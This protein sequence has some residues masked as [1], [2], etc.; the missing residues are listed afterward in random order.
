[1]AANRGVLIFGAG[2]LASVMAHHLRHETPTTVVG[3]TV[4]RQYCT[5]DRFDGL[6]LVP[7]EEASTRFPPDSCEMLLPL[8]WTGMNAL[9]RERLCQAR[10]MGYMIGRFVAASAC[11]AQ[12]VSP[13]ENTCI[14]E[15]TII[16]PFCEIGENVHIRSGVVLSHHVRV[17]DDCF[18]GARAVAGGRVRIGSRCVIG[19]GAVLRN[20][21][22]V[23]DGCFIG[24]G[25]VVVADTE[26][27]G[28][29]VGCPARRIE[30]SPLD[31]TGG[32]A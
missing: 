27:D 8:G 4:D 20:G 24:A 14:D 29:Y 23:A 2:D 5:S 10:A 18:I 11:V 1:M 25:A 30:R 7:F 32:V 17:G 26:P 16:G 22:H 6:A 15:G 12:G 3:F 21:V 9:R 13:G 31:V 19:L 28:V